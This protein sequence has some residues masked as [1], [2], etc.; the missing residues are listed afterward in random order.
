MEQQL[1]DLD[2][3]ADANTWKIHALGSA[4]QQA[5]TENERRLVTVHREHEEKLHLMFR[6]YTGTGTSSSADTK[7]D[8]PIALPSTSYPIP[9]TNLRKLQGAA[10][11]QTTKVTRQKNKLIIQQQTK[12]SK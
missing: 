8:E 4:L 3:Q 11:L 10:L 12:D 5:K 1:A 7:I 2:R 6:Q 9:H